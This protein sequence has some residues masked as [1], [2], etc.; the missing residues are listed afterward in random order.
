MQ[1][2]PHTEKD[3]E[4]MLKK[5]GVGSF[6]ELLST[7]PKE[8]ML[9]KKLNLP[10][11]LS[12]L[13]VS[14]LLS[15]LAHKN[16]LGTTFIGGGVYDHFIP[17]VVDVV[18][19]RPEFYTAYTPYQ[20][21]VS[22]GTLQSIFEYQSMICELTGMDVSN[23]SMYDGASALAESVHMA[24]SITSRNEI[25]LSDLINPNYIEVV[26]TYCWGLNVKIDVVPHKNG[27]TDL[28]KLAEMMDEKKSCFLLQHPNFFGCLE[29]VD[30]IEKIVHR[31]GALFVV[32]VD[33]IS[34]GLLKPPGEYNVDIAVG[35]GQP[36]G[37]PP[38]FGGPFLG[39]FTTKKEYVRQLPGRLVG[40][41]VDTEG[42]RGYILTMQTRE[43]HIRRERATS[44][45]CTNEALCALAC[46]VYLSLL[47]KKGIQ[48][49]AEL[50]VQKSHYLYERIGKLNGFSTAFN[51]PFFKE[52]VIR[53]KS[54][55]EEIL[56][57][58][59][60]KNIFGGLALS[61]FR[62][63]WKDLLLVAV[64]EKRTKEDMDRLV[65]ELKS[66]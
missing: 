11:P 46:C 1:F 30:E 8:A 64:T 57:N 60:S 59:A 25:L 22:Q 47:G 40:E 7:M 55:P 58:L 44:N 4:E 42:K 50:C 15:S 65:E 51:A 29:E 56:K 18:C 49:V 24:R 52:F 66:L 63:E 20:A 12:E 9:A 45:I 31:N 37:L 19:S 3:K 34:L 23:A 2:I 21:E 17:A 28:D 54:S 38:N 16:R 10:K 61:K 53:C 26:K 43:Q 48:E 41:T 35:E 27:Q 5:I 36:L 13:Q 14:D 62:V 39:I 6:E 32:C 33:P